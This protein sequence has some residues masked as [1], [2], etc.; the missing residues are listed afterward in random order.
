MTT[1]GTLY[2]STDESSRHDRTCFQITDL[3]VVIVRWETLRAARRDV[4]V[5]TDQRP[6]ETLQPL[7][8]APQLILRTHMTSDKR[9]RFLYNVDCC[10]ALCSSDL[11]PLR[12]VQLYGGF[13][14]LKVFLQLTE[15][16]F[17]CFIQHFFLA[18]DAAA[19]VEVRGV[20]QAASAELLHVRQLKQGAV[21][22][23]QSR[24]GPVQDQRL[25]LPVLL[26]E[27]VQ[28]DRTDQTL[29]EITRRVKA[30]RSG[31]AVHDL[32]LLDRYIL[33]LLLLITLLQSSAF[34][35]HLFITFTALSRQLADDSGISVKYMLFSLCKTYNMLYICK[36]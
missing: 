14:L 33:L 22:R 34:L 15:L 3:D 36:I 19:D 1:D 8:N 26:E 2:Y 30:Q 18:V 32:H 4:D 9:C 7:L 21:I 31:G 28:P 5:R 25:L 29:E 16:D 11:K 20:S 23:G 12:L 27:L 35:W 17:S 13:L 6:K 10:I 24:V